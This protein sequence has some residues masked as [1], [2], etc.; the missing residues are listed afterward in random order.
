[1]RRLAV[2]KI[3]NILF[4]T[5]FSEDSGYALTYARTLAELCNTK[6]HIVH[7]IENPLEHLYGV[8]H[9]EY[10]ALQANAI[11]KVHELIHRFD[12]VLAGFTNFELSTK[13][14]E[15]SLEILK[16]AEE[17]HAGVIVMGTH[18]GGALR[19]LLLGGTVDKVLRSANVPV[20]VVRH[21][22]RHLPNHS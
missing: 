11:K 19:N 4:A 22:N 10:P 17:K 21:P 12:D 15:A 5:D 6:L 2:V 3:E 18:G 7:V 9:G 14:G 1:M 8:P 20:M 16:A 13:E